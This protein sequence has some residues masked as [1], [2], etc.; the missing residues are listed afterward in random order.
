MPELFDRLLTLADVQLLID[1]EERESEL[2]EYKTAPKALGDNEKNEAAKDISAFANSL[3]GLLVYGVATDPADK[4][5]PVRIDGIDPAI[6]DQVLL[7]ANRV[8]HPVAGIRAKTIDAGG[9]RVVLL[10]VVPASPLAP[11]QVTQSHRYYRRQGIESV[12][13][14]HDLVELYFGRRM[15]PVLELRCSLEI[16]RPNDPGALNEIALRGTIVNIG[17]R[18]GKLAMA[19]VQMARRPWIGEAV[20]LAR[21]W[22]GQQY[23]ETSDGRVWRLPFGG[24]LFYPGLGISCIDVRVNVM[25]TRAVGRE[26]TILTLDLYAEE[27]QPRRYACYLSRAN[28]EGRLELTAEYVGPSPEL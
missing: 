25:D 11:H 13:M 7:A 12:P 28:P 20:R 26:H 8:R 14:A 9:G 23:E 15:S 5:K 6:V 4:S 3:G 17:Q 21:V 1:E 19:R 24:E 16:I 27:M 22:S 10:V 2:L 18:T